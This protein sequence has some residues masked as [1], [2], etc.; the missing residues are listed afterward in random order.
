VL[1]PLLGHVVFAEFAKSLDHETA[2]P[3]RRGQTSWRRSAGCLE[4]AMDLD[5]ANWFDER[6]DVGRPNAGEEEGDATAG[7]G[8]Q[9]GEGFG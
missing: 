6:P 3:P 8:D 5:A 1:A 9:A 7:S 2:E 4:G